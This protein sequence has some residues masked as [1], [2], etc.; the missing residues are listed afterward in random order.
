MSTSYNDVVSRLPNQGW[1][2]RVIV[3]RCGAVVDVFVVVSTRYV[4]LVDTLL[5]P[6]T[7]AALLDIA[8]PYLTGG[9]QLLIVNTHADWDHVWGNQVF[10]GPAALLPAPI[11]GTRKCAGR[12]RSLEARREL[13]AL[14]EREPGR[15]DDV[16]LTPPTLLFD[17]RLAVDGGD[18]TLELLA[19]PGHTPDHCAVYIPQIGML[20][21]GDAAE[22]PFPLVDSAADL[23][24][25]R[26]SLERMAALQ[27]TAALYCHAPVTSGPALLHANLAH[28][29][30][31]ER[32]CRDALARGVPALP[33][34]TADVEAL[35]GYP[36]AEAIPPGLD[37]PPGWADLYRAMH[38]RALRAMLEH[39]AHNPGPEAAAA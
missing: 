23:P 32:R 8:R 38:R 11:I 34:A 16:Q 33:D 18:L 14:R 17:E 30:D 19:T 10:A 26:R 31:L 5:N 7:A 4:V 25:L 37:L 35:I 9:R 36:F 28:F 6:A 13:A 1:D 22:A 2:E 29:A 27:L 24:I 20:L 15:F 39:C 3:V 12:L 21:A